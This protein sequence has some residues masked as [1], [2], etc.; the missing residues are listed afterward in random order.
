MD[1][2]IDVPKTGELALHLERLIAAP[3]ELVFRA[4]IE[5]VHLVRWSAPHGFDIPECGGEARPGGRWH[6]T[7]CSPEG[8][9]LRLVGTYREIVPPERLV[10]T[11]A[12]LEDDGREGP[13]TLITVTF[14]EAPGGTL[15]GFTQTGFASEGARDG[16]ADGWS[17]CFERLAAY[18]PEMP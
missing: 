17:Q 8:R 13:E 11:H 2:T 16:H 5:P 9:M 3:R 14:A 10:F 6:T 4:W 1:T 7:M 18:L 12:W 15:L